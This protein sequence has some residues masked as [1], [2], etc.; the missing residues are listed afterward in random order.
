MGS[1]ILG[2]RGKEKNRGPWGGVS[3][4]WMVERNRVMWAEGVERKVSI[5]GWVGVLGR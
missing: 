5:G 3:S 1:E 2:Q 4:P